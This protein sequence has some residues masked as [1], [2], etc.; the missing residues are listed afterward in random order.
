MNITFLLTQLPDN[1][2]SG[3]LIVVCKVC[4]IHFKR[5]P[6]LFFFFYKVISD[7]FL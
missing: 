6:Q 4:A 5:E 3:Y 2:I 7:S 1:V